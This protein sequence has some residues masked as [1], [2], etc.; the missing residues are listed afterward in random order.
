MRWK[1]RMKTS[2][3]LTILLVS[4][5]V[6]AEMAPAP[7]CEQALWQEYAEQLRGIRGQL[8]LIVVR[9]AAEVRR[10]QAE[11]EVARTAAQPPAAQ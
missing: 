6:A 9:Q 4:A 7:P 2:L 3:V 8:E 10:L 1:K 5:P 11:L